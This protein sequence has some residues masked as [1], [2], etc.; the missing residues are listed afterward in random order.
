MHGFLSR[1]GM[2]P[3]DLLAV[4]RG[5]AAAYGVDFIEGNVV[6]VEP[7]FTVAVADGET[8]EARR[9]LIATGAIDEPARWSPAGTTARG[10]R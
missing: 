10:R 3:A 7:G 6:S 2:P 8:V 9:L 1:D 4:G 5:E